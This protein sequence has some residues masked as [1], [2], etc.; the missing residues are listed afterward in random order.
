MTAL[1]S[2]LWVTGT[3]TF[4]FAGVQFHM[5]LWKHSNGQHN[6][7]RSP[8][9]NRNLRN[10]LNDHLFLHNWDFHNVLGRLPC[11]ELFLMDLVV[12][13]LIKFI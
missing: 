4:C 11:N 7:F 12:H 5:L 13:K 10:F 9:H 3:C 6:L 1:C 8:V 2:W